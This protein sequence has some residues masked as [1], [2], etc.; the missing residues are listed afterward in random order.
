[1]H[2]QR[3]EKPPRTLSSSSTGS[4]VSM[5]A[6]RRSKSKPV[7][8]QPIDNNV[9]RSTA[10]QS[11]SNKIASTSKSGS[12]RRTAE[13]SSSTLHASTTT[14]SSASWQVNR[15]HKHGFLWLTVFSSLSSVKKVY[16]ETSKDTSRFFPRQFES[17]LLV[18]SACTKSF[19]NLSIQT[20]SCGSTR[21]KVP[22]KAKRWNQFDRSARSSSTEHTYKVKC[23]VK[24]TT[25]GQCTT[26][27]S[28]TPTRWSRS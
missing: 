15:A 2:R 3:G 5:P 19:T 18:K 6:D 17:T 14:S 10:S 12:T 20:S 16:L 13:A 25:L 7:V 27:T 9:R 8:L 11:S 1:M 21:R 24:S 26:R 28:S 4:A 22:F 23:F